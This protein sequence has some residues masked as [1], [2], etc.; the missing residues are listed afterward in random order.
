MQVY[1]YNC[2]MAQVT[3]YLP[4]D[5]ADQLRREAERAK[6][7]LSAYV[8]EKIYPDHQRHNWPDGFGSLFG[9]CSLHEP[10]SESAEERDPL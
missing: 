2:Y 3:L 7:S 10:E 6:K 4:D 5:L 8:S 1:N 9:A